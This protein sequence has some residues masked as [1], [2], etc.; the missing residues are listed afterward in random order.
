M[1]ALKPEDR[2]TGG[3]VL[4]LVAERP[5]PVK[6][7]KLIFALTALIYFQSRVAERPKPV[8]ALKRSP[9]ENGK[10]ALESK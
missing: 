5:K 4:V 8:K 3:E 10:S 2:A 6:A 1:K 7:L 9:N